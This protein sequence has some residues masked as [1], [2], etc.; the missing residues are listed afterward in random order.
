[1][2]DQPYYSEEDMRVLQ[3]AEEI[4]ANSSRWSA[5]KKVAKQQLKALAKVTATKPPSIRKGGK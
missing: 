2:N 5:A 4:K 3:R 1:M